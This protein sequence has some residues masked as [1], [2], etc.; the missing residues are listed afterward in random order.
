VLKWDVRVDDRTHRIGGGQVVHVACQHY[1]DV[2]TVWTI[3]PRNGAGL[4]KRTVQVYGTGHPLPFFA[5]HL[6]TALAANGHLVWHLF[7]LPEI[8]PKLPGVDDV[9]LPETLTD[10]ADAT[11]RIAP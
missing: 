9:E 3:E 7:A 4:P 11:T 2:V 10:T 6:G 8:E 1:D 5:E